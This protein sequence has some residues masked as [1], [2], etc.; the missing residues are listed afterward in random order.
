M[1]ILTKPHVNNR[2]SIQNAT[3]RFLT[4]V[5]SREKLQTSNKNTIFD[6]CKNSSTI[7]KVCKKFDRFKSR[8]ALYLVLSI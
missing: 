8:K 7:K 6:I 4:K 2:K 3:H 5:L 1:L